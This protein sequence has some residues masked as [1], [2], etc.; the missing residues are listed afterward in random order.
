MRRGL[1]LSKYNCIWD[2]RL[3]F[4][5]IAG[6]FTNKHA[7][8]LGKPAIFK[9]IKS[10][11]LLVV[12]LCGFM[13]LTSCTTTKTKMTEINQDFGSLSNRLICYQENQSQARERQQKALMHIRDMIQQENPGIQKRELVFNPPE[14]I[15]GGKNAVTVA[16]ENIAPPRVD[17]S[18]QDAVARFRIACEK[19]NKKNFNLAAEDF[20]FSFTNAQDANLKA[21]S[22]YWA[23]ESFYQNREWGRAIQCYARFESLYPDHAMAPKAIFKH[24]CSN[25]NNGNINEGKKSFLLLLDNHPLTKEASMARERLRELGM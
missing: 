1:I 8:V 9:F 12:M 13:F 3:Q 24:G 7:A 15:S 4:S 19:Y 22:L 10:T 20:I 14:D 23:G 16:A 6:C 18:Q 11:V 5:N 21:Q 17:E 25:I 2:L